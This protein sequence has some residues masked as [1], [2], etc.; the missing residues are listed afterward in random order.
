MNKLHRFPRHRLELRLVK[1]GTGYRV[2]DMRPMGVR[3]RAWMPHSAMAAQRKALRRRG[4]YFAPV[5]P[6]LHVHHE[7]HT[8][9]RRRA[10]PLNQNG[11][12]LFHLL[13]RGIHNELIMHL[14]HE[15][16]L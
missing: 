12:G 2:R 10:H 11:L 5:S 8:Q 1:E 15:L 16:R 13:G 9:L 4:L 7:R 6:S 14:H 3:Q